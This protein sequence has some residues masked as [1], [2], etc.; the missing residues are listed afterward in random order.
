MKIPRWLIVTAAVLLAALLAFR[1]SGVVYAMLVLPVSY[2]LW[3]LKLLYLAMPGNIWWSVLVLA[4][5][6]LFVSSLAP[7]ALRLQGKETFRQPAMGGVETLSLWMEKSRNGIYYKWLVANR[8]G[9]I[10]HRLLEGR[11]AGDKRLASD[12]LSGPGWTPPPRV[13]AYLE[14]GLLGSFADYPRGSNPLARSAP[15][16]LDTDIAEVVEFIE[17][18]MDN[19]AER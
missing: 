10:A 15:T 8:L 18:K 16:P 5:L 9:K 17:S 3:L 11:G 14:T 4:L 13:H 6:F 2:L 1:L 12:G 7:D 19:R